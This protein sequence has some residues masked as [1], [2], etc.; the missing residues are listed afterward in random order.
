MITSKL[1]SSSVSVIIFIVSNYNFDIFFKFVICKEFNQWCGSWCM[2]LKSGKTWPWLWAYLGMFTLPMVT[3]SYHVFSNFP[4]LTLTSSV[5]GLK[6]SSHLRLTCACCIY[7]SPS[8]L[9]LISWRWCIAVL[10]KLSDVADRQ[11]FFSMCQGLAS[12]ASQS[13][14]I[15]SLFS[16]KY[17]CTGRWWYAYHHRYAYHTLSSTGV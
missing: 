7:L 12:E 3:F 8:L 4:T 15:V 1:G 5:W 9:K 2:L 11:V 17:P 14:T 10:L 16:E 6:S 13:F